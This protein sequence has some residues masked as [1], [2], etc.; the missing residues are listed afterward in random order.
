MH[1]KIIVGYF[2]EWKVKEEYLN[3]SIEELPWNLLTHINYAFMKIK[4]GRVSPIDEN[5][6]A[7]NMKTFKEL[8]EKHKNVKV[9]ISIGGW[10]DSGEFSDVALTRE[11][12]LNFAK[13]ALEIIREFSLDGIDIDWEFPVEGGLPTNKTRPEDKQNFTYLLKDIREELLKAEE[14]DN[15]HYLLTIAAP[16]S[17]Q[18]IHNTEP[19]KYHIYLDFINLMTYDFHG[20]WDKYTNHHSPLFSNPKDPNP[21]SREKANC[22][23]AVKEYFKYGVPSEKIILGV[24]FYG[25]GWIC[26]DDGDNGLFAKVIGIPIGIYD[27]EDH[28]SGSNP[29]FFIKGVLE[30]NPNYLK[31]RDEYARVPW[32]WN[33]KEKIFYTY[34]DEISIKEKCK[35]V[36]KNGLGGIMIWEIT[37]D[38]PYK[39]NT[40]LKII[41][42]NFKGE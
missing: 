35:Y 18:I 21:L 3:Y 32:L 22:D 30:N 37:E 1:K 27:S 7:K 4:D 38:Y 2:P 39:G 15:K 29:F 6:F 10:T 14:K 42:E 36:L 5:L 41:H 12:R 16:A 31:F 9:L 24:P 28:P 11:S 23:F 34:D 19:D 8:K 33:P 25:K 17:F 40:L 20:V 26:E 13:S